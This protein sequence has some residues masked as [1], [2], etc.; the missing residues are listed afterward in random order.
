MTESLFYTADHIAF[1]DVV[2]RFVQKEIE[3]FAT[4]WDEAGGFPRELYEKAAAIGLL[5]LGFPE[6][7]GGTPTDQFMWIV[8]TQELARAGAGGVSASLNSHSIGAPPIARAGTPELKARVLPDIL[9][10]KKI[11]ALAITEPSGGSDVANLRTTAKRDGDHYVVNGEKTFITSGMRADYI[12][13]AVRTGGDG[14]GGVSLLLIPGDTPGLTRTPLKKMGWWASDTATLHFDNCRVP[15]GNLLGQE[16]AGFMIIML[17]FNSER[18]TMAAGCIAASRVCLD[19]ATAYAKERVTFGKP[20]SKHQVIRH[21]LVDMAQ[22]IAASQAMLELLAW[23]VEQGESPIA[24]ICMLKNQATQTMAFCASEAV[25]IFGGAGFMRGVKVERI[26]REV[27][28]NAIGGGTEE[29]MKD[30]ASRQ[31]GL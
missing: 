27:K 6:E 12:T 18:L 21:K 17:N 14:P 7:Y 15:A 31:M 13:T 29:I 5:G 24:E 9:A 10:G 28:V 25:Q 26:Y 11:S 19:E 2:R 20:L 22:R 23:R 16:G 4:E 8:A 3:P 1:R 30:L